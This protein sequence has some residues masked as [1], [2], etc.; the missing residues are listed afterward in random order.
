M[1]N[2]FIILLLAGV[3]LAFPGVEKSPKIIG[4][5][6]VIP[7]SAPFMVSLQLY[8]SDSFVHLCGATII[9]PSWVISAAHCRA[10]QGLDARF[11]ILAGQVDFSA[12]SAVTQI[13]EVEQFILHES[14]DLS[15]GHFPND[16]MLVQL[17]DFLIFSIGYVQ[18]VSLPVS[19]SI[20]SGE[21]ESFGWGSI[22]GQSVILPDI[23]QMVSKPIIEFELCREI[24]DFKMNRPTITSQQVCRLRLV[25]KIFL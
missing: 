24:V 1:E 13:R 19:S 3:A 9:T 7:Y 12:P 5:Q 18:P 2:V 10:K 20:P 8:R 17:E 25:E 16:I 11:R 22:S 4:G 14:F 21:V 15:L 23:L 6:D